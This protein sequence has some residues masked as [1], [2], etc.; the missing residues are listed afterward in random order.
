M[1][2]GIHISVGLKNK[3]NLFIYSINKMQLQQTE[4][5]VSYNS[6][7]FV[8]KYF[9][10]KRTCF[11]RLCR[12]E[13]N[14]GIKRIIDM[15]YK[16]INLSNSDKEILLI[17]Y[18]NIVKKIENKYRKNSSFYTMST[19]F[20]GLS[21]ILVT[22]FISINNLKDNAQYISTGI[23]WLAWTLSLGISLVNMVASFYKW[24]RKYLL[25][26]KVFYKLEQEMWMYLELIG[27]YGKKKDEE[28]STKNHKLNIQLFYS[29]IEFIYKKVNDNLL[30]IEENEQ[31]EK[32]NKT[33]KL[34]S[35]EQPYPD[36][37]T[38]NNNNNNNNNFIKIGKKVTL[39]TP[40]SSLNLNSD[41]V[42]VDINNKKDDDS[43][44]NLSEEKLANILKKKEEESL[45]FSSEELKNARDSINENI[46]E[47]NNNLTTIAEET[48]DSTIKANS[49]TKKE[50][51]NTYKEN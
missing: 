36:T 39:K 17:R 24:D 29:R 19:L 28:D 9:E 26:F 47:K 12:N 34:T 46:K 38:D 2:T 27:P 30:D 37:Q 14:K 35:S 50:S 6:Y 33:V 21:S 8:N 51:P 1:D 18:I 15:V 25:M 44:D 16:N 41:S 48:E 42:K 11:S 43:L 23:W 49:N 31:D 32:D 13:T 22:A 40:D 4:I 7:E 10:E 3:L 5:D 20:T 45:E